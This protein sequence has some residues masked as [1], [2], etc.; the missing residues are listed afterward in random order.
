MPGF[1]SGFQKSLVGEEN[2]EKTRE[3]TTYSD[4]QLR[5][6]SS[7]LPETG[8]GLVISIQTMGE[9]WLRNCIDVTF[10][11]LFM[12]GV[13]LFADFT[14]KKSCTFQITGSKH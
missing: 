8:F 1:C 12:L 10:S 4:A 14:D 9:G 11:E 13:T 2:K 6:Q 3:N 5:Y 7:L